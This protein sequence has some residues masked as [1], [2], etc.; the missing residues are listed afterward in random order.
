MFR[1]Y[2]AVV[3]LA[4][5]GGGGLGASIPGTFDKPQFDGRIIGGSATQINLFPWQVSM[6]RNGA[7]SCGGAIYNERIIITAA[8]C[9]QATFP[10]SIKIRA[11]STRWSSG[12]VMVSVAE[13]VAHPNY[14]AKDM[15][16]D[17]GII[18]LAEPL[19]FG[20]TIQP[21]ALATMSPPH[22]AAAVVSGWGAT[23]YG[24]HMLPSK[25]MNVNVNIVGREVCSSSAYGYGTEITSTMLCAAAIGKDACQGDSGGPLVSG[26]KLVGV[27]SWGYGCANP[28]YPGIYSDVSVLYPWIIEAAAKF[29]ETS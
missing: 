5:I 4:C 24:A 11:G 15:S 14:S 20:E 28:N 27:V 25:L 10:R 29:T 23:T 26:G 8:H 21:I 16:N 17:I 6:Q 19:T 9:L 2:V 13:I 1:F 3:A 18:V 7:H 12:G 22:G